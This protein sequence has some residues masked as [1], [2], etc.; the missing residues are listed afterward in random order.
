M[1]R[2]GRNDIHL[3]ILGSRRAAR[4]AVAFGSPLGVSIYLH[5]IAGSQGEE[6]VAQICDLLLGR[7]HLRCHDRIDA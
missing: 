3:N 4:R 5:T 6:H 7:N 1:S 2:R